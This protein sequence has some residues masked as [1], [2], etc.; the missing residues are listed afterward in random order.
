LAVGVL[1]G[2]FGVG[3][4]FV[5]VPTLVLWLDLG[6]RR[7]I[8]TSLVIVSLVSAAGLASHLA[9]GGQADVDLTAAF[10]AGAA[11]G[12]LVGATI[13]PAVRQARLARGFALVVACLAAFLV[14]QGVFLGGPPGG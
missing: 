7:A 8:G 9:T 13:S 4:G 1:T 12:T 11:A 6:M 5:I 14:V 3:G 10:A 2:F